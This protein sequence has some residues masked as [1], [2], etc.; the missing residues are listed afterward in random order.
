MP[1]HAELR[2]NYLSECSVLLFASS[3]VTVKNC[4]N[5]KIYIFFL[6]QNKQ[7]NRNKE[8]P[9]LRR[10]SELPVDQCTMKALTDYKRTEDYL[11]TP[12]DVNV[13]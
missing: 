4:D 12:P 8:K 11:N 13:G 9:L 10:K 3:F 6:F 5:W 2:R 7:R 1:K